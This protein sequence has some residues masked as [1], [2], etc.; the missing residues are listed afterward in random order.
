MNLMRACAV[1]MLMLLALVTTA[2]SQTPVTETGST[3]NNVPKWD[4]SG[5]NLINSSIF[6]SNRN[7]GSGT[8]FPVHE[9][10]YSA[11]DSCPAF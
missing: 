3:Q 10:V 5:T 7:V 1:A 11:R 8:K 2:V 4:A 6:D 9:G